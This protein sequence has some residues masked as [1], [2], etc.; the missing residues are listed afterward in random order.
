MKVIAN[1]SV[2]SSFS[3]LIG[4]NVVVEALPATAKIGVTYVSATSAILALYAPNKQFVNVIGDFNNWTPDNNS[5]MK[6]TPD[7]NIWWVQIN[8]LTA[9]AEYAYQY[10]V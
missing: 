2:E 8:N 5:F 6:R 10:L 3:F 9:N 1:N 4:G 7:G